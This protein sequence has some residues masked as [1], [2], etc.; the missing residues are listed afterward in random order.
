MPQESPRLIL[1]LLNSERHRIARC[2]A[3]LDYNWNRRTR[4]DTA[5]YLH[6]DLHRPL[7]QTRRDARVEDLC[8]QSAHGR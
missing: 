3:Y 2:I 8:W 5:R 4:R 1:Y 6:V 7:H